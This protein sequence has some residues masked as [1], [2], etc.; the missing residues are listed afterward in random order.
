MPDGH[1]VIAGSPFPKTKWF[2][3]VFN[4]LGP[5]GGEGFIVYYDRV[6]W[7][8]SGWKTPKTHDVGPGEVVI[9]QFNHV[10][11]SLMIGELLFFNRK[12][13]LEEIQILHD[14]DE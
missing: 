13:T 14:M 5:N 4:F 8:T 11:S 7:L 10:Y 1:F 6:E 2:H 3:L 12:L 9:G